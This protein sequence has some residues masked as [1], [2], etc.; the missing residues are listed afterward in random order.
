MEKRSQGKE[1]EAN[2]G[3]I[4]DEGQPPNASSV[5]TGGIPEL[6]V[7]YE[8]HNPSDFSNLNLSILTSHLQII[9]FR[10]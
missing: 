9:V 5:K 6:N 1:K 8:F 10:R 4:G 2:D 3:K 7:A